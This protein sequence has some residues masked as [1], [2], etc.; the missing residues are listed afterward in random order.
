MLQLFD[1]YENAECA[2]ILDEVASNLGGNSDE[3]IHPPVAG[4]FI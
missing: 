1:L 3:H 4:N 2:L